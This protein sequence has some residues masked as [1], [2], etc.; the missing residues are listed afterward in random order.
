MGYACG[1]N[2][3]GDITLNLVASGAP[4][5]HLIDLYPMLFLGHGKA[6]WDY[7]IPFLAFAQD[8]PGL[9]LGYRIPTY[10]MA[11]EVVA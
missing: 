5:T 1:F 7:S 11:I 10:R 2:S 6:P 4:G 9:S 8:Y 3:Q